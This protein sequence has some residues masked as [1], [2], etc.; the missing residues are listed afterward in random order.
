LKNFFDFLGQNLTQVRFWL[1]DVGSLQPKE[2][3]SYTISLRSA[4]T[5]C[6]ATTSGI[7]ANLFPLLWSPTMMKHYRGGQ[8][9]LH[10]K[11]IKI[12]DKS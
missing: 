7:K 1:I 3:V 2:E 8:S 4:Q 6:D 12:L 10:K 5:H 11:F 9:K